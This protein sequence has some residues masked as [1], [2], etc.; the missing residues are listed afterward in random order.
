MC[1]QQ[2][3]VMRI[4]WTSGDWKLSLPGDLECAWTGVLVSYCTCI[5]CEPEFCVCDNFVEAPPQCIC[6]QARH[7]II[8]PLAEEHERYRERNGQL[9][10]NLAL[11]GPLPPD[12]WYQLL[13]VHLAGS[14][15]PL[16]CWWRA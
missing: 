7:R 1:E 4:I 14:C 6:D 13:V 15:P 12:T 11:V 2:I 5:N 16:Q 8:N 3:L 9:S 10:L